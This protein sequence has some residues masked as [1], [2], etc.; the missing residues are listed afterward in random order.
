MP[1]L[2]YRHRKGISTF[3]DLNNKEEEDDSTNNNFFTG[4]E[5]SG[6]QVE[7]PNKKD[8]DNEGSIIEQIF[9]RAREQMS[10]EHDSPQA[11]EPEEVHFS[12][13]GF[14]LGGE[15]TPSERVED[16]SRFM[17]KKPKKV[18]REITFWKQGFTVGDGP[19]HRYD[20][21]KNTRILNDLNAG[22]VPVSLLN[23][24]FGQ[25]VDVSVFK[26]TNEDWVPPKRKVGGYHGRGMRLGSPVPGES[27]GSPEPVKE[28]EPTNLPEQEDE[29]DGD[30]PI[31]I[32]FANG[33]RAS[34]K[35]NSSDPFSV[36]YDFVRNHPNTAQGRSF[37]LSLSFPIK[38]I[39]DSNDVSI[40]DLK[41]KNSVLVQ[42]WN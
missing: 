26:R 37:I 24:E 16:N 8:G 29:G 19:L 11:S 25:D 21:P 41:L 42:K 32:R 13:A 36:V 12:G 2:T 28:P 15:D 17:P 3:K 38:P 27:L 31:Q 10:E 39:E 20:D 6:L 5:K 22:R 18:V 40:G 14:K 30:T 23:V 9:N 7:D 34:H 35:F 1:L 4:G 33:K